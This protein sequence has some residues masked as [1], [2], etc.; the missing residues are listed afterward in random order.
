[1]RQFPTSINSKSQPVFKTEP[2]FPKNWKKM[3]FQVNIHKIEQY[4][5]GRWMR[6][7][8]KIDPREQAIMLKELRQCFDTLDKDKSGTLCVEE[9]YEPLLSTGLVEK[10]QEVEQ[11]VE[12][13]GSKSS[14]I[15]EF[16][17]FL[18]AFDLTRAKKNKKMD[19]LLFNMRKGVIDGRA[20]VVSWDLAVSNKRRELMLGAYLGET[21]QEKEK[22]LKVL[23]AYESI[24]NNFTDSPSKLQRI[25]WRRSSDYSK[26][27]SR[28]A[29]YKSRYEKIS[30]STNTLRRTMKI[31]IP[32]SLSTGRQEKIFPKV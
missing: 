1:M 18:R 10:R 27:N 21:P 19:Q 8:G 32:E 26:I 5:M 17:E 9:L 11:L 16:N 31:S 12:Y 29:A 30:S 14:G 3:Q 13:L 7:R 2:T 15:I 22:G 25:I 23:K 24:L 28:I 20:A 6:L 4:N